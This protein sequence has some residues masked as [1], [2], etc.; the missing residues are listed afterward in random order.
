MALTSPR[1]KDNPELR[2]IEAGQL[3]L[4]MGS[5][6]H[7]VHLLQMALLDLGFAMPR[8]TAIQI[9]SRLADSS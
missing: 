2:K 8:S 5:R 4:K 6:G 3:L 1:F 9:A 7:H